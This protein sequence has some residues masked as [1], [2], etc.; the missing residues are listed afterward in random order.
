EVRGQKSETNYPTHNKLK[1]VDTNIALAQILPAF[2]TKF[3]CL[4][5]RFLFARWKANLECDRRGAAVVHL[6]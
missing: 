3:I 2:F 4:S 5:S 1:C 6:G